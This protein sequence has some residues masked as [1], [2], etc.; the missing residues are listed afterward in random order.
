MVCI[1][2]EEQRLIQGN[3]QLSIIIKNDLISIR[4]EPWDGGRITELI[5]RITGIN[6]IWTNERTRNL[7]RYY[8]ANYDD[9]SNS[10]IEEAFPTVGPCDIGDAKLPFFGEIW[11][12]PWDYKVKTASTSEISIQLSCF[13]AIYP[14]KICK[15]YTITEGSSD[16]LVEYSIENIGA[17]RFDFVFGVHPSISIFPKMIM[18][19]PIGDYK[20]NY[21]YPPRQDNEE[22]FTW[23]LHND[24]NLSIV[25]DPNDNYCINMYTTDTSEGKYSFY[26]PSSKN[27]ISVIFDSSLFRS[28]SIWLIYGGWRGHYC[29]MTEFFT[30]WPSSLNEARKTGE[31]IKLDA[32][33]IIRT[34]VVYQLMRTQ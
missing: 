27:G 20:V 23:P 10:G 8:S 32:H 4:I 12:I 29:A 9:L 21:I 30:S 2:N 3:N 15:V 14:A 1:Y 33:S 34:S 24:R 7:Y 16:L 17:E 28:L 31:A 19:M 13:S 25:G 5:D 18:Q 26:D 6:Y 22:S 11:T